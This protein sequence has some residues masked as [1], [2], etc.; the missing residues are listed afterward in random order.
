MVRL[1]GTDPHRGP[2]YGKVMWYRP[3]S[4]AGPI[5]ERLC[6]TDPHQGPVMVRLCG[7]DPHRGRPRYRA[8]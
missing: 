7:I 4:R 6:G 3:T 1:C 8:L 5:I 2:R